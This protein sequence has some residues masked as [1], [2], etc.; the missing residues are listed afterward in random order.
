MIT[1]FKLY[2]SINKG[3]LKIGDYVICDD[4]SDVPEHSIEFIKNNIGKYVKFITNSVYSYIIEYEN[5]PNECKS[6]FEENM[7]N[8]INCRRMELKEIKYWSKDKKELEEVLAANK[9]NI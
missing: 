5:I 2:E 3:K 4:K 1:K 7:F 6:E 8:D 9:Y